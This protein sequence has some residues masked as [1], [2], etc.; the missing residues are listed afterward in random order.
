ML[1]TLFSSNLYIIYALLLTYKSTINFSIGAYRLT[2]F[3]SVQKT[4]TLLISKLD[5]DILPYARFL[6]S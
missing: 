1:A 3:T 4:G 6:K 5:R 2:I